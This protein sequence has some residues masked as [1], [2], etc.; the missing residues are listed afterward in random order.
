MGL[1]PL[2]NGLKEPEQDGKEE[3][4]MMTPTTMF[5]TF[6]GV[7]SVSAQLTKLL[8]WVDEPERRH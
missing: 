1:Y 2:Y 3:P 8:I 7:C 5:L 4:N 6:V